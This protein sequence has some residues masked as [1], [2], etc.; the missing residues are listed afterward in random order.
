MSVA[1]V[2]R[3]QCKRMAQRT[4]VVGNTVFAF[5]KDGVAEVRDVGN[6]RVD[7]GMLIKRPGVS[8]LENAVALPPDAP[9]PPM[10]NPKFRKAEPA[11]DPVVE[12][13]A[14][15][16][17]VVPLDIPFDAEVPADIFSAPADV[18]ASALLAEMT[19]KKRGRPKK[20]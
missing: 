6:T 12:A 17:P 13:P 3:A 5:N 11:P 9:T 20:L 7:Y 1:G 15:V 16:A 18:A 14:D 8:A 19:P 2:L 10:G 4:L